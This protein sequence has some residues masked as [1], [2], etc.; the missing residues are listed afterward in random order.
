[1]RSSNMS[2]RKITAK[3][4]MAERK[5]LRVVRISRD[6]QFDRRIAISSG[7]KDGSEARG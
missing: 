3:C 4:R 5:L 6:S 2:N 7:K 1:M